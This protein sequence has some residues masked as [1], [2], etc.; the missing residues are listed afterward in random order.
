[1]YFESMKY[2]KELILLIFILLAIIMVVYELSYLNQ[3]K[4]KIVEILLHLWTHCS[5]I[6]FF[7]FYKSTIEIEFMISLFVF[8]NILFAK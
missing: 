3:C 1:M 7:F 6:T 5:N 2:L 8:F 4:F